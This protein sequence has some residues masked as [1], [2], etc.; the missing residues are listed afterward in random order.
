MTTHSLLQSRYEDPQAR[1][2][3]EQE[4]TV[5]EIANKIHEVM[6]VQDVSRADLANRLGTSRAHITQVLSGSRNMTLR[7]VSDVGWALGLRVSIDFGPLDTIDYSPLDIP[8]ARVRPRI[9]LTDDWIEK[10][11]DKG[12]LTRTGEFAVNQEVSIAA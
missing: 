8:N 5:L 3:F 2:V 12:Q 9:V 4:R 10:E 6:V 11:S 1:K 7:T